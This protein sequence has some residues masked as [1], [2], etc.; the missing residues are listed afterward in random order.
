MSV[1]GIAALPVERSLS[2][3]GLVVLAI[4]SLDMSLEQS[5]ILPALPARGVRSVLVG[6]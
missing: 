2:V 1:A 5:M 6:C 3:A 4:G